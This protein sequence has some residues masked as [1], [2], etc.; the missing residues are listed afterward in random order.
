MKQTHKMLPFI[1]VL[2][3]LAVAAPVYPQTSPS[4]LVTE[5]IDETKLVTLHGNVHP[6]SQAAYDRGAVADA[7]PAERV[8]LLLNRPAGRETALQQFLR[9]VHTRG[10]ASYHRWLTPEQFGEQFGPADADIQAAAN[11]LQSQGFNVARVTKSKQF[12][13]FSGNAGQLRNAFHTEIHQYDVNG[14]THYANASEISIPAALA[15]LV[16]GVSPLNNFRAEPYIKVAGRALYSRDTK[17]TTP[18]WTI[19]NPEGT[20]NPYAY[21]VAP[22]DLATQYDLTPLYQAGVNGAGHYRRVE[23]RSEFGERLPTVIRPF[24]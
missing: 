24:D 10:S 12:I 18:L 5:P 7:L 6:L 22:E 2:V 19:P 9:D 8:L 14:E 17:R 23:Y 1:I 11:W 4:P 16:R 13:E 21:S 20:P 3:V 15:R